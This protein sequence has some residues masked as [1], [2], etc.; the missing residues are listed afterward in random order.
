MT[1]PETK[2]LAA[3]LTMVA[4]V[5]FAFAQGSLRERVHYEINVSHELK[6]GEYVLPPGRYVLQQT[7][8]TDQNLFALFR[9]DDTHSPLA[10]I[11]TTRVDHQ[12][13]DYPEKTTIR[14]NIDET[15]DTAR[16]VFRGWNV[17]G[18]D[19]WEIIAVDGK[20]SKLVRIR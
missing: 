8:T 13:G 1:R 18:Q 16:P 10:L 15:T 3:I 7:S 6:M 4:A 14:L 17:P 5:S 12:P 19:G 11:R 2:M 20:D 9:G